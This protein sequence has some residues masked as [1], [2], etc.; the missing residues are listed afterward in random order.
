L[1]LIQIIYFGISWFNDL[2]ESNQFWRVML[3][4]TSQKRVRIPSKK[5]SRSCDRSLLDKNVGIPNADRLICV[6][7]QGMK[8]NFHYLCKSLL[9]QMQT[10][11]NLRRVSSQEWQFSALVFIRVIDLSSHHGK[12]RIMLRPR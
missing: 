10:I 3:I 1:E 7:S 5:A 2:Q 12:K 11:V 8:N 9:E 6:S 4:A